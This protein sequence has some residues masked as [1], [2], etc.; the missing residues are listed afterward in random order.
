M[1]TSL[2]ELKKDR[3]LVYS[4]DWEMTPESAVRVYLEWGNIYAKGDATRVRSKQDHSIYFVVNCWDRPYYIY[5]IK[6][7]SQ[8]AIELAKIELPERFEKTFCL[9]R[10]VFGIED[11]LKEWLKKGLDY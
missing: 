10:G 9:A 5:L 7:N 2:E 1:I 3:E 6:R 11:E 4:I 8:E